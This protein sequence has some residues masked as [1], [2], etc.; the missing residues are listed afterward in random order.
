MDLSD[1]DVAQIPY[2]YMDTGVQA[3]TE[4]LAYAHRGDRHG[5][6]GADQGRYPGQS[7]G[8]RRWR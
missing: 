2:I 4:G 6:H 5:D 7:P 1:W 3:T 8:S